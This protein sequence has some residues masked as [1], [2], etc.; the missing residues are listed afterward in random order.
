MTAAPLKLR[1]SPLVHVPD[2]PHFRGHMTAAPLK[3]VRGR[4]D[5]RRDAHFR[6]HMTAAPLKPRPPPPTAHLPAGHFRGH[7]TAAPLKLHVEQM[8]RL[9]GAD[10]RGHM[11]AAPLKRVM[12]R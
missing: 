6:G 2:L 1:F 11:T 3:L 12:A 7:M 10:F 8:L 5:D 4:V 9:L